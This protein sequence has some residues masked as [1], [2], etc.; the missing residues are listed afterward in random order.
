MIANNGTLAAALKKPRPS[1]R[2]ALYEY[3]GL[4]AMTVAGPVSGQ[5]YR[6]ASPGA[7]AQVDMRD[8]A[9]MASLPNLQ[10]LE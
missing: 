2:A 4:T 6:F 9:S 1:S 10:R 7:K 5:T 8:V 3:T